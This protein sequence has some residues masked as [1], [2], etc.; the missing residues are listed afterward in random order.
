MLAISPVDCI[1]VA[2]LAIDAVVEWLSK[3]TVEQKRRR[4][5]IAMT[6]FRRK[7]KEKQTNLQS[8]CRRL[9]KQVKQITASF[10]E[11]SACVSSTKSQPTRASLRELMVEIED[12]REQNGAL[13]KE[14]RQRQKYVQVVLQA[15][16]P[17]PGDD[18]PILPTNDQSG[19]RVRFPNDEPSFHFHPFNHSTF[20]AVVDS[21]FTELS[22]SPPSISLAGEFLG[23]KVH[24]ATVTS[25]F[26]ERTL[27]ARAHFTKRI[28]CSLQT[29]F[30]AMNKE[31][32]DSWPVIVTPLNWG[33][34]AVGCASTVVLQEFDEN[35]SVAVCNVN[36]DVNLRYIYLAHRS[37]WTEEIC[38]RV[39][40]Y[41]MVI[42][43]SEANKRSRSAEANQSEVHWITE[44]GA[45]L[46]LTE[47]DDN[48]ID[49]VYN[50]WGECD[51]GLHA[52][53]LFVQWAHYA[54]HWEQKVLPL[55]LLEP[56]HSIVCDEEAF[57]G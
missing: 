13:Q 51:S 28:R 12:L 45:H 29:V 15:S 56:E 11:A 39:I 2:D 14:I 17:E 19:W 24:H 22:S 44:G 37:K 5:R 47:V 3:D 21:C 34:A 31:D 27:T 33:S 6:Q 32:R 7:R 20:N 57:S 41:A 43:D 1:D 35:S 46:M 52:Q 23:W 4:H 25:E 49:V 42:S 9:E 50:H 26:E 55:K 48:N 30:M 40:S 10:R 16:Q 53:Y 8:E 36:G 38:K 18:E 54:F